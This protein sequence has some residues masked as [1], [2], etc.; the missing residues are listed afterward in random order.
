MAF[1][2]YLQIMEVLQTCLYSNSVNVSSIQWYQPEGYYHQTHPFHSSLPSCSGT[3]SN[4][5]IT[6]R[7][8]PDFATSHCDP[9]LN[10][11]H[12]ATPAA[13]AI[14]GCYHCENNN[15]ETTNNF[16]C[17]FSS[18]PVINDT[19]KSIAISQYVAWC[20]MAALEDQL[21]KQSYQKPAAPK[22]LNDSDED[23]PPAKR[24]RLNGTPQIDPQIDRNDI[25]KISS[26]S[27]VPFFPYT[28]LSPSSSSDDDNKLYSITPLN[29]S[30]QVVS[31]KQ[32][33]DALFVAVPIRKRS[34]HRGSGGPPQTSA[35][36][37][38]VLSS[39][40]GS[41]VSLA[42]KTASSINGA[43]KTAVNIV[44]LGLINLE[45]TT[46]MEDCDHGIEDQEYYQNQ[47]NRIHWNED[48]QLVFPNFYYTKNE[49]NSD[50]KPAPFCEDTND[51]VDDQ[52]LPGFDCTI[53]TDMKLKDCSLQAYY[54]PLIQLQLPCGAWPLSPA[55]SAITKVSIK[56][57]L[58]LP[59]SNGHSSHY[60][61]DGQSNPGHVWATALAIAFLK[62]NYDWLKAEWNLVVLKG[63]QWI[64]LNKECVPLPITDINKTALQLINS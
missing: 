50:T 18:T 56:K 1:S 26:M 28:Y 40:G 38:S 63:H 21:L 29:E 10:S 52:H 15:L 57:I 48:R 61:Q 32:P 4:H 55:L 22:P 7:K 42:G 39:V 35:A 20:K 19:K 17:T 9:S 37:G 45:T 23:S 5:S 12:Q 54:I 33:A 27:G 60:S 59:V 31:E 2:E 47:T 34:R 8:V 64:S 43:F 6:L 44:S 14:N 49:E 30:S 41:L 46:Q 25:I 36:A 62:T 24:Q 13:V 53:S 16:N 3:V 11:S 58:E 51:E